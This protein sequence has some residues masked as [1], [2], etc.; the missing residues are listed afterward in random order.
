[1]GWMAVLVSTITLVAN[2]G[3]NVFLN[4]WISFWTE[5]TYLQNATLIGTNEY[6]DLKYYYLGMYGFMGVL[7]GMFALGC[8]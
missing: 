8:P 6:D 3:L 1:M 2:Q 7:Q 5:D 4:F